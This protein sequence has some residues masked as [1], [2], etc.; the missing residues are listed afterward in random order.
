MCS[1]NK[2][3]Q[4]APY[5]ETEAATRNAAFYYSNSEVLCENVCE[6]RLVVLKNVVVLH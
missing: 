4:W 5:K 3:S 1:L 2:L 6:K